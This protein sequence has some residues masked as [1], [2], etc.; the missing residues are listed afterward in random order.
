V[1]GAYLAE[2][3]EADAA[4]SVAEIYVDIRSTLGLPVVNLVYRHLAVAPG[5][6][7]ATWRELRPNL[8][9][10]AMEK[11]AHDLAASVSLPALAAISV[12]TL[13]VVIDPEELAGIARTIDA[14]E[15]A[16]SR[17]LLAITALLHPVG[18]PRVEADEAAGEQRAARVEAPML[19][20]MADPRGLDAR[21]RELLEEISAAAAS[22][23]EA[24]LVPSLFRHLVHNRCFLAVLWTAVREA[25]SSDEV[26][27]ASERVSERAVVL[28]H[29]LPH[30]C[31]PLSDD[32]LRAALQ[33]FARTIPRMIVVGT[34]L[35]RALSHTSGR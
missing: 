31:R 21:L 15:R 2:V 6:L 23:G 30:P 17:N 4:G 10:P 27:L 22:P 18:R 16:N 13:A 32:D 3:A 26:L 11:A 24:I 7:E 34:L 1:S 12:A 35:R 28:A 9:H 29:E 25:M 20:P 19:P 14:Y 5:R 33:R 8:V